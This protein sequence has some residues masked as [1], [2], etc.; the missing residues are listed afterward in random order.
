MKT[1]SQKIN[2]FFKKESQEFVSDARYICNDIIR[3][4]KK[5]LSERCFILGLIIGLVLHLVF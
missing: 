2:F 1:L 4:F 5:V 3:I